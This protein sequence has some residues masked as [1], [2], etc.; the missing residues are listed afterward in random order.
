MLDANVI[1]YTGMMLMYFAG[2]PQRKALLFEL[3][4]KE[5]IRVPYP[6]STTIASVSS[7]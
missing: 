2:G 4:K 6:H 3:K 5:A 1:K 7:S